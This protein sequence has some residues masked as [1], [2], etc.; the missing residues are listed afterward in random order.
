MKQSKIGKLKVGTIFTLPKGTEKWQVIAQEGKTAHVAHYPNGYDTTMGAQCKAF[1]DPAQPSYYGEY[2]SYGYAIYTE[3]EHGTYTVY[4]AGNSTKDGA[5][6]LV[7]CKDTL[8]ADK[9][10]EFCENTGKEL[11]LENGAVWQGVQFDDSDCA[12]I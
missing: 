12:P 2:N 11:A 3:N 9:L 6:Y 8:S 5:V 4:S 1:F 7:P 10:R